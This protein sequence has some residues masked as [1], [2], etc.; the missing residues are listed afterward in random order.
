M[1]L[2]T[3]YHDLGSLSNYLSKNILS[4][5]ALLNASK[6]IARGLVHLHM[7]IVGVSTLTTTTNSRL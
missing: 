1:L 7:E 4:P 5:N 6:S 2:I 3:E